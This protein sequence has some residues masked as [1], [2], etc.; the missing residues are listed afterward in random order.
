[1][2]VSNET[3]PSLYDYL[4]LL[5]NYTWHGPNILWILLIYT[6]IYFKGMRYHV[7]KV[8]QSFL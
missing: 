3:G 2:C 7:I 4:F 6:N 5:I 8:T 1:M